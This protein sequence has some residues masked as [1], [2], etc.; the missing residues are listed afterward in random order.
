M[1]NAKE[2]L[3]GM[4]KAQKGPVYNIAVSEFWYPAEEQTKKFFEIAQT[5]TGDYKISSREMKLIDQ[6]VKTIDFKA[7]VI[8]E[9][10]SIIDFGCGDGAKA[11]L[12][13][14]SLPQQIKKVVYFPVDVSQYMLKS[15]ANTV[16]KCRDFDEKNIYFEGFDYYLKR[17]RYH[18]SQLLTWIGENEK[19]LENLIQKLKTMFNLGDYEKFKS[20]V[21]T[22]FLEASVYLLE[23]KKKEFLKFKNMLLGKELSDKQISILSEYFGHT[24][25]EALGPPLLDISTFIKRDLKGESVEEFRKTLERY[26]RCIRRYIQELDINNPDLRKYLSSYLSEKKEGRKL[27]IIPLRVN[28]K[29]IENINAVINWLSP[30]F[31]GKKMVLFLGHTLGNFRNEERY[32]LLTKMRIILKQR[33]LLLLGIELLHDR[34]KI[35]N[36]YKDKKIGN[37]LMETMKII[38]F[39]KEDVDYD[40]RFRGDTIEMFFRLNK[41]AVVEGKS[42][43]KNDEIVVAMS[44]KF[45]E[46]DIRTI[47]FGHVPFNI[48]AWLKSEGYLLA[49]CIRGL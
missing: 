7:S 10:I 3:L 35:L 8:S 20:M 34:Q 5:Q 47:L 44:H 18:Y 46:Q 43:K 17:M 31:R 12:I 16:Y 41:N 33:D 38:G 40:A 39:R 22:K 30:H 36:A 27:I 28:F 15:A 25:P 23:N 1:A 9:E 4:L 19:D 14:N 24:L 21:N 13:I 2:I 26:E 48:E 32:E 45:K 11:Q 37:F 42:F 29:S 6:L 49:L